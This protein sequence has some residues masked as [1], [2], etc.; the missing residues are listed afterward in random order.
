MGRLIP[1]N[2][3]SFARPGQLGPVMGHEHDNT[4]MYGPVAMHHAV[5][6]GLAA[7]GA[8]QDLSKPVIEGISK[9][10]ETDPR[11]EALARIQAEAK[12]QAAAEAMRAQPAEPNPHSR[13]RM[14]ME[15]G[16]SGPQT[17]ASEEQGGYHEPNSHVDENGHPIMLRT[18]PKIHTSMNGPIAV[19][20]T[21]VGKPNMAATPEDVIHFNI[22][23]GNRTGD[24]ADRTIERAMDPAK[25]QT[26]STGQS[27][28]LIPDSQLSPKGIAARDALG[29]RQEL[30]DLGNSAVPPVDEHPDPLQRQLIDER[31]TYEKMLNVEKAHREEADWA[32]LKRL[33]PRLAA[34]VAA[35]AELN[36]RPVQG[37]ATIHEPGPNSPTAMDVFASLNAKQQAARQAM[38]LP[39]EQPAMAPPRVI[40]SPMKQTAD[41]PVQ[42]APVAS[43]VPPLPTT[44]PPVAKSDAEMLMELRGKSIPSVKKEWDSFAAQSIEKAKKQ[45][46]LT[47]EEL[48]AATGMYTHRQLKAMMA[49]ARVVG[50]HDAMRHVLKLS[51]QSGGLGVNPQSYSDLMTG[52]HHDRALD[53]LVKMGGEPKTQHEKSVLEQ[54]IELENYKGKVD[55]NR[56]RPTLNNDKVVTKGAEATN[57][58][59]VQGNKAL[60]TTA[61]ATIK[62]EE[63]KH[64]PVVQ[65]AKEGIATAD[66]EIKGAQATHAVDNEIAKAAKNKADARDSVNKAAVSKEYYAGRNRLQTAGANLKDLQ[67]ELAGAD[68]KTRDELNRAKINFYNNS[69]GFKLDSEKKGV[70]WKALS[71]VVK[72][73]NDA[74]EE[75][76]K[77][78]SKG[79]YKSA[80]DYLHRATRLENEKDR[81]EALSKVRGLQ[82]IIK[83]KTGQLKKYHI[84]FNKDTNGQEVIDLEEFIKQF[85]PQGKTDK[86]ADGGDENE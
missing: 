68:L 17:S 22:Q 82:E 9:A 57:A 16:P 20:R 46:P 51:Q 35:K 3:E 83:S 2:G 12:Q 72:D 67:T 27:A 44:P 75:L 66:A 6:A 15:P 69:W 78:L 36:R 26:L 37:L 30:H 34:A 52:A 13:S 54:M 63:A 45:I 73:L 18:G 49:E 84:K 50:D 80:E 32:E 60:T 48:S 28:S 25:G 31:G 11:K 14:G 65:A 76:S 47:E 24:Q 58:P 23:S 81:E 39:V 77:L 70:A 61:D 21:P 79:G 40:N 29:Q 5:A 19:P 38:G 62:G 33:N 10:S 42:E 85:Q 71:P 59:V 74:Q 41:V 56:V 64:A 43:S 4:A 53:E 8:V 86:P 55:D 7:L 1:L